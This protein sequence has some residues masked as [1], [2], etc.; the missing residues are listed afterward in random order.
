MIPIVDKPAIQ[1]VVEE[2]VESGL[3]DILIVT[4]RGKRAIEDHFDTNEELENHLARNGR[5]DALESLKELMN[6][7]HIHYV[8]QPVPR[9]LGDAVA[10]AESF[11]SGE[12]FAVLLADD[13]TMDPPCIR[14]LLEAHRR[15]GGS[16]VALQNVPRAEI[17]RYGMA[18]GEEVEPGVYRL[19]DLIEKPAA[20]KAQSTL[21]TIGRYVLAPSIF[22]HL[23]ANMPG[24]GGEVQL[25]DA[26]RLQ[27]AKEDVH[28]LLFTGRRYDVGDKPGWL[29]ATFDLAMEREEFRGVLRNLTSSLKTG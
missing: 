18:V 24:K 28:G 22:K 10:H 25:T 6:R 13:L 7:A 15:L 12:P 1:Y 9:G 19:T 21:A 5:M 16:V 8:R 2:A 27:L 11:V 3:H 14:I 29:R 4:G 26:I 20:D 17:G 23:R